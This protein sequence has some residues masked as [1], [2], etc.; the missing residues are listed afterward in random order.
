MILT[1]NDYDKINKGKEFLTELG[2]NL[3]ADPNK[4]TVEDL[5]KYAAIMATTCMIMDIPTPMPDDHKDTWLLTYYIIGVMVDEKH[6]WDTAMIKIK[7]KLVHNIKETLLMLK[8]IKA[9]MIVREKEIT[10]KVVH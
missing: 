3:T 7:S 2:M 1:N 5:T 8:D 10:K 4:I 9:A 6:Y